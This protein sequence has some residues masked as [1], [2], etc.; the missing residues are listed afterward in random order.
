MTI[1]D[2]R[3]SSTTLPATP[4]KFNSYSKYYGRGGAEKNFHNSLPITPLLFN[5][6]R[7]VYRAWRV[8]EFDLGASN[9]F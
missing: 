2:C 6:E 5:R 1:R 3:K 8:R 4:I 7:G 9:L